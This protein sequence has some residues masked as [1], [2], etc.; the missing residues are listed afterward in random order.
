LSKLYILAPSNSQRNPST[1]SFEV[2]PVKEMLPLRATICKQVNQNDLTMF[3]K[4]L[5]IQQRF[6]LTSINMSNGPLGGPMAKQ[7]LIAFLFGN[8]KF[9]KDSIPGIPLIVVSIGLKSSVMNGFTIFAI[10]GERV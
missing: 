9:Q 5:P 8:N 2:A 4:N 1:L 3:N 7:F 6:L 10:V